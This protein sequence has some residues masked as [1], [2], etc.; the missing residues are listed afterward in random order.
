M[1]EELRAAR[2]VRSDEAAASKKATGKTSRFFGVNW[3]KQSRRWH[4]QVWRGGKKHYIGYY[5]DDVDAAREVDKW[6]SDNGRRRVNLDADDK[7]LEWQTNYAS[8]YV[9]VYKNGGNWQARIKVRGT[10]EDLGTYR[11]QK[12]AALAFDWR[13]RLLRRGTNF[14]LDGTCNELGKRGKVL[15]QVEDKPAG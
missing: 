15:T 7:P 14:R 13:A 5:D 11:T 4:A 1:Q 2:A 6:L 9:G 12:E 3:D 10:L 8:V